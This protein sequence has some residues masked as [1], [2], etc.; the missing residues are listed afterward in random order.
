MASGR[1]ETIIERR[2]LA[3][4]LRQAGLAYR[5]I[6]TTLTQKGFP[7][8]Y[9]TAY[10]DVKTVLQ[11]IIDET[12]EK[13]EQLRTLELQRLDTM[14]KAIWDKVVSGDEK[15]VD[16]ALKIQER[17]SRLLGLDAPSQVKLDSDIINIVI[18]KP[19]EY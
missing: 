9:A 14:M 4:K 1:K 19:D 13:A 8:H 10:T 2:K 16:R 15:A 5:D 6:A 17:R 3:L 18:K 11:E 12:S 7:C